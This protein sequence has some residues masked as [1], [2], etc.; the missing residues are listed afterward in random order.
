ME[1][2]VGDFYYKYS[3]CY[4]RM[5]A[6]DFFLI[7]EIIEN[8]VI[9]ARQISISVILNRDKEGSLVKEYYCDKEKVVSIGEEKLLKIYLKTKVIGKTTY[10]DIIDIT[11]KH[12]L[13]NTY[14]IIQKMFC[15]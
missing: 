3:S 4:G 15:M 8:K 1:Y 13:E 7:K 14:K 10:Q 12:S 9:I 11:K 6:Y 2:N 5:F